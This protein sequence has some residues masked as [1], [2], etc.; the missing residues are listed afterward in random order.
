MDG[1]WL[2]AE[3]QFEILIME[4]TGKF[5]FRVIGPIVIP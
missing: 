2:G 3:Y 5:C 1:C 4:D